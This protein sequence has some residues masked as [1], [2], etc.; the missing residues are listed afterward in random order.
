MAE[1]QQQQPPADPKAPRDGA[2]WGILGK[3]KIA[4]LLLGI[5]LIECAAAVFF[6]PSAAET[7][8]MAAD[9]AH[10]KAETAP[11]PEDTK[12]FPA[13]EPGAPMVEV[14]L[15]EFGVTSYQ[16]L[17][18]TTLRIDFQLYATVKAEDEEEF[19]PL[20]EKNKHRFREQV[21]V[22]LRA[23]EMTD[24]TDAGLGLIKRRILEKT[25]RLLNEPLVQ[26]VIVSEFSFLEQ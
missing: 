21:L 22:I 24:L 15:G 23:A 8:A 7:E 4:G 13:A 9:V 26:D 19:H 1:K 17:T 14:A 20:F 11:L 5:V 16:P 18:N 12:L 10:A 2:K 25:N 3:L 6:L